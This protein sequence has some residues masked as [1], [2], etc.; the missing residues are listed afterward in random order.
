MI[1]LSHISLLFVKKA[2]HRKGIAKELVNTIKDLCKNQGT[3]S[4]T[5]NSSPYAVDVYRRLGFKNTDSEK[6]LCKIRFTQM[7]YLLK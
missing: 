2:Y 4:I 1:N 7:I 3:N 6:I 5:V